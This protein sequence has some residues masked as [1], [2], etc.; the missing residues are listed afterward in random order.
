MISR[1]LD[2]LFLF[3]L[4]IFNLLFN[5]YKFTK[6]IALMIPGSNLL[7]DDRLKMPNYILVFEIVKKKKGSSEYAAN[8]GRRLMILDNGTYVIVSQLYNLPAKFIV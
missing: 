7:P 8:L 1:F 3:F 6:Q 5:D 4:M 2:F